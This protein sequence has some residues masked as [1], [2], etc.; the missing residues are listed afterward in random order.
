MCVVLDRTCQKQVKDKTNT[1]WGYFV[2]N[3]CAM[4]VGHDDVTE[5]PVLTSQQMC[6]CNDVYACMSLFK[7]I[8]INNIGSFLLR[9]QVR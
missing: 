2:C 6:L 7:C 9:Q 5:A 8:S 1:I 4:P 3:A